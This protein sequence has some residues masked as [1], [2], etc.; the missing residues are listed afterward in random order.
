[1]SEQCVERKLLS[2][3]L[4]GSVDDTFTGQEARLVVLWLSEYYGKLMVEATERELQLLLQLER[5]RNL[6]G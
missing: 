6:C 5:G 4:M 1:M 2:K 3:M